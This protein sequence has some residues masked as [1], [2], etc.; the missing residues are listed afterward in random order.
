MAFFATNRAG[1][2]RHVLWDELTISAAM[3]M[4]VSAPMMTAAAPALHRRAQRAEGWGE[5]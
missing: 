3:A 5:G 2:E 1:Q 4:H